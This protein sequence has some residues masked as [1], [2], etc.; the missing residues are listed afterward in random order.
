MQ[1]SSSNHEDSRVVRLD[2]SLDTNTSPQVQAFLDQVIEAAPTR[3][4]LDF[5]G[6]DYISSAGL[7]VLLATGKKLKRKGGE[8]RICALN[9]MAHEVFA[10]SGFDTLF[11][12]H[13]SVDEALR[14]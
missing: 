10:I 7:R 5:G 8:L 9:D 12:I 13:P 2:G 6:L 4:V 1:L 11:Q 14:G 3:V